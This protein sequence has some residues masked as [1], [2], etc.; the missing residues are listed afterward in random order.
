MLKQMLQSKK[1]LVSISGVAFVLLNEVSGLVVQEETVL[2]VA[3]IIVAYIVGQ[4][5]ADKG[6]ESVKE[7]AKVVKRR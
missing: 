5:I 4:G 1:F 6:K 2:T 7:A 3:G